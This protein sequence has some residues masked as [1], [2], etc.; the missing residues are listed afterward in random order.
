[1][2]DVDDTV[3]KFHTSNLIQCP[4]CKHMISVTLTEAE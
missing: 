2:K 4:C 3:L 1:M